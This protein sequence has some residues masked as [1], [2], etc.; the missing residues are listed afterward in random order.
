MK[1]NSI[2]KNSFLAQLDKVMQLAKARK[3]AFGRLASALTGEDAQKESKKN[4][5]N[6]SNKNKNQKTNIQ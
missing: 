3:E 1:K 4:N 2:H 5:P 6:T